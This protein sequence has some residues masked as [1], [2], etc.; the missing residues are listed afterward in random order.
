MTSGIHRNEYGGEADGM[1]VG[2]DSRR[3]S[4]LGW[5]ELSDFIHLL[6]TDFL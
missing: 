6:R 1:A 2:R 3:A 4:L 5:I